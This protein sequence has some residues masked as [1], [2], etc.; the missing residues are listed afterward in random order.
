LDFSSVSVSLLVHATEDYDELMKMVKGSLGL[1][2]E[3]VS[4]EKIKGYFG[5]EIVSV[6]V[7][8]IGLRA[9]AVGGQI[10]S[11]LSKNARSLLL[12]ELEKSM[13]EHDSLYFRVDR[14]TL[15][16]GQIELSDEEPIR[17]KIKP[18]SRYGGREFM[19]KQFTEL[20]K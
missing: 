17:V 11:R 5:N 16:S 8:V 15:G 1:E 19:K 2:E 18:R 9:K 6:K 20:I 4:A 12:S 13:D 14:Q 3:E 10:F 7:H